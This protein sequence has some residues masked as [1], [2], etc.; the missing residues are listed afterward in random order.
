MLTLLEP[1][2]RLTSTL[3]LAGLPSVKNAR[4]Q[5]A[6]RQGAL[7]APHGAAVSRAAETRTPLAPWL[8]VSEVPPLFP[9]PFRT[10]LHIPE[11]QSFPEFC[12][13]RQQIQ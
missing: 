8:Q 5:R 13:P 1:Q 3:G 2:F 10:D 4:L 12:G 6:A 11:V 7:P 9:H